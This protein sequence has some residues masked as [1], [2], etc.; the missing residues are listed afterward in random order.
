MT[1]PMDLTGKTI[2]VTGASGGLGRDAAIFLSQM[3]ARL[4]LAARNQETLEQTRSELVA[5]DQHIVAPYD[6]L[7]AAGIPAWIKTLCAEHGPLNG[8]VHSA[9]IVQLNP[10][11]TINVEQMEKLMRVNVT[12]AMMLT[13]GLRQKNCHQPMASVV[14]LS[15]VA[16]LVGQAAVASYSASKGALIAMTRALARE[17]AHVPIRVNCVAPGLTETAMLDTFY[18]HAP[19]E[20]VD[21]ML[22]LHLLGLGKPRQV[23]HAIGF[24]LAETGSWITGT[25]LVVDGGY[26]STK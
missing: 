4:V 17:L 13:R 6:M 24:L 16:G 1:N 7:D 12:A 20:A 23:S 22:K 3:G 25:T 15:S 21:A 19:P 14:F 5:P 10:L 2:L 26:S 11:P 8:L 9:G 18:E